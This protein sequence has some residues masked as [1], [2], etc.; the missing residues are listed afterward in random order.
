MK[1]TKAF[2][3][4]VLEL[5][6]DKS[7]LFNGSMTEGQFEAQLRCAGITQENAIV[8]TMALVLAGA[9]FANN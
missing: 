5:W 1:T 9:K 6:K 8:I 2:A 7:C 3:K 4:E